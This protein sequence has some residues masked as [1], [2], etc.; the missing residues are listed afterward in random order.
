MPQR[1]DPAA[2]AI[3]A[4]RH[5][6]P[7]GFLGM[8]EAEEGLCVRAFLP[9]A[10]AMAVVDSASGVVAA[11]GKRVHPAG[12]FVALMPERRDRFRY[13]LRARRGDQW[14]EFD[15]VYRF[16]PVLGELDLH[17]LAEGSHLASDRKLGAHPIE[18]DG[19]AGIAF[20]VWAP[21]ARRVSVE[22][23]RAHV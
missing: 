23:G 10:A 18:H 6:D 7:F 8:H 19:V 11:T 22:I 9:D 2:A 4:A 21:N 12:L 5:G 3:V 15:D 13:R 14:Q 16:S 20:A 17:L 1:A